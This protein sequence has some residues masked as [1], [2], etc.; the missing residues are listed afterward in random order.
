M[1]GF[2]HSVESFATF[3]GGGIRCAIFMQGCPLR[4]KFCHNPDTWTADS[5]AFLYEPEE[6]LKKI[7]R[8]R[9]Y[10]AN[11]G[12][13][14]FTG[15][16]PLLQAEFVLETVRLLKRHGINTAVDTSCCFFNDTVKNL[17]VEVDT[18]IADL[19]FPDKSL[20][21]S[22]CGLDI[23]DTVTKTLSYLSDIN[24]DVIL[25]TVVIPGIND[26]EEGLFPYLSLIKDYKN[27]RSYELK[28]F[29]TM[30]FSKYTDA[31][32]KNPYADK[33]ALPPERLDRLNTFF[34]NLFAK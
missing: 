29:H 3:E 33:N 31:G 2:I 5:S 27:I 24:K 25:R 12:G 8:F 22:E 10:F 26:T 7:L 6:L 32:I 19:K 16:E 18:V 30:G 14:T 13:V 15:G 34:Q 21:I 4:C 9:P 23:F 11:D 28:P 20:Y 1:R 17:Y